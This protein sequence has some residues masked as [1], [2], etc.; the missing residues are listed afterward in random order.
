[1]QSPIFSIITVVYNGAKFLPQTIE[2]VLWQTYTNYEYLI[3]DG[4]S[5]DNSVELIQAYQA[6]NARIKWVSEPDNGLYDAMNKGLRMA[7]G[8]YVWFLN[9]GDTIATL[10][11]LAS[12]KQVIDNQHIDVFYGDTMLVDSN[13]KPIGL[14]SQL[15]TRSLPNP[16]KVS[17]YLY[18]M[19]VVH[20][21]FIPRLA[22]CPEYRTDNLCADY[23]WC[24]EILKQ[25]VQVEKVPEKA[26][27][28][29]L[30]GGISKKRH[31]ESLK[32]RFSVMRKHFGLPATVW[33]HLVIVVRA[34]EHKLLRLGK[35][36]Y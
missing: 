15:T 1:M 22:L 26:V 28:N 9:A 13:R 21:S 2:S 35:P 5:K 24:I 27:S 14:M 18:G 36:S 30:A 8:T 33:A 6:I 25:A 3:I 32:D 4:A 17:D 12:M 31:W 23:D 19:R 10:T 7:T 11:I 34:L 16:L 20:Q 29:Y